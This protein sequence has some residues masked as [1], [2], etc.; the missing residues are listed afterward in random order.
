V[1]PHVQKHIPPSLI[2]RHRQICQLVQEL[3]EVDLGRGQ[4]GEPIPLSCHLV[5]RAVSEVFPFFRVHDG[6]FNRF[7]QH[8]WLIAYEEFLLDPYPIAMLG[9]PILMHVVYPGVWWS[10]YQD[11]PLRVVRS[12]RFRRNEAYVRIA[13]RQTAVRLGLSYDDA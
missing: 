13:A 1:T 7:A 3:P 6:H 12:A 8:S 11:R 9:G 2:E 5:A 10:L 4:D